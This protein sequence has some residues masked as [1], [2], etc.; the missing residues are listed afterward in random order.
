MVTVTAQLTPSTDTKPVVVKVE[1]ELSGKQWCSRFPGSRDTSTLRPSFQ[2]PVSDFIAAMERAGA[3]VTPNATFRPK[4]RAYLMETCWLI[5]N[6]FLQPENAPRR[7]G[8]NIE[9][10][11]PTKEKSVAAAKAMRDGYDMQRLLTKPAGEKSLHC[12]GEAIDMNVSWSGSLTIEQ[13]DGTSTTI[14]ST[15]RTGMNAELAKV[16]AGYGVI[17]YLG[18]EADRP[19]WST[20]GR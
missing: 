13:R 3:K 11:H 20:T 18:G 4:E 14:S 9:W 8:V 16:G 1:K 19:H 6:G 2:L 5:A 17:K 15:P 12:I 10:V 7:E